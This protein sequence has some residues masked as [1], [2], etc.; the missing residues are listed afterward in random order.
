MWVLKWLDLVQRRHNPLSPLPEIRPLFTNLCGDLFPKPGDAAFLNLLQETV[1]PIWK[2]THGVSR[3]REFMYG[4]CRIFSNSLLG[5]FGFSTVQ[6]EVLAVCLKQQRTHS[7]TDLA[8]FTQATHIKC[9][10]KPDLTPAKCASLK[11]PVVIL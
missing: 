10:Q 2:R 5:D 6:F 3:K 9:R 11:L 7:F 1:P 4:P 8:A